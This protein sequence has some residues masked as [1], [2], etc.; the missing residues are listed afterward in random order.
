MRLCQGSDQSN[1]L[2]APGLEAGPRRGQERPRRANQRQPTVGFSGESV[3]PLCAWAI[4]GTAS[5][6]NVS[7]AS[8]YAGGSPY[9]DGAIE[10]AETATSNVA[11]R[12][13]QAR[14]GFTNP[15]STQSVAN[16]RKQLCPG[17]LLSP[18]K[19]RRRPVSETVQWAAPFPNSRW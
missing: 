16:P 18:D 5:T 7:M 17:R 3:R 12:K 1:L 4:A 9:Q 6:A 2:L 13:F 15:V 11:A 10:Q 8:D 19:E 14:Y